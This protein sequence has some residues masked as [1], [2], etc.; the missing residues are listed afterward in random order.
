M[1]FQQN[2]SRLGR[3]AF[4][5]S[6][7][8]GLGFL[9]T[10]GVPEGGCGA[11]FEVEGVTAEV[12]QQASEPSSL[13]CHSDSSRAQLL[14]E[15]SLSTT[16]AAGLQVSFTFDEELRFSD[17]FCDPVLQ[18]SCSSL[19]DSGHQVQFSEH[20]EGLTLLSYS[21][22]GKLLPSGTTFY[23]VFDGLSADVAAVK[24]GELILS[25][26]YGRNVSTKAPGLEKALTVRRQQQTSWLD[27]ALEH[28]AIERLTST[29]CIK[30]CSSGGNVPGYGQ[31]MRG[32]LPR[33]VDEP[34]PLK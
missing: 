23:L 15:F 29:E 32:C 20:D 18:A 2:V 22:D 30:I 21:M 24:V 16:D 26:R 5:L 19:A 27:S 28:R 8:A 13:D 14:C 4:V 31:C 17:V 11:D 33:I 12:E 25:D 10:L 7:A 9:F 3:L 34:R 1:P 6:I